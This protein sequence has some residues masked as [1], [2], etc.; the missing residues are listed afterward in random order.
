MS[1]SN[2]L[3]VEQ[4]EAEEKEALKDVEIKRELPPSQEIPVSEEESKKDEPVIN[5][6]YIKFLNDLLKSNQEHQSEEAKQVAESEKFEF[7]KI[8][9]E[10]PVTF[11]LGDLARSADIRIRELQ[12]KWSRVNNALRLARSSYL[13]EDE[14]G[15]NEFKISDYLGVSLFKDAG[16]TGESSREQVIEVLDELNEKVYQERLETLAKEFF[17]ITPEEIDSVYV[18]KKVTFLTDIA[19]SI[20]S[21]RPY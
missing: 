12:R 14:E 3:S 8:N 11:T 6:P 17:G 1:N 2:T 9:G 20:Y 13:K 16:I 19:F 18:Y 21:V 15:Y 5:N 4:L 10:P 7:T